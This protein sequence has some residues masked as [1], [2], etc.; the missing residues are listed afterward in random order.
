MASRRKTPAAELPSH[1]LDE[2]PATLGSLADAILTLRTREEMLRFLRDLC[3]APELEAL[4]HRWEIAN[5]LE[6][7]VPYLEIS[8]RVGTSTTTVTRVAQWLRNGTGGYRLALD[9]LAKKR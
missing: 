5:L 6:R 9:R 3:T 7:G 8:S 1:A 2:V 4:A